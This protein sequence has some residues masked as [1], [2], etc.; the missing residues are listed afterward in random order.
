MGGEALGPQKAQ[1]PS[2]EGC[3]DRK[4]GVGVLVSSWRW[5][6]IGFFVGETKKGISLK[7]K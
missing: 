1:C 4:A 7:C 3:Q 5:D 2:I 6:G